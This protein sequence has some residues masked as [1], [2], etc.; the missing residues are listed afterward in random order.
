[1]KDYGKL[2]RPLTDLLK[3]NAFCWHE[4]ATKAFNQLKLAMS[5]PPVLVLPDFSRD[6]VVETDASNTRIGA[7]L[8]QQG[9]PIA[10]FSKSLAVQHQG[11]LVYGKEML[12]VVNAV[13]KWR[14]YLLGGHFIIKTDH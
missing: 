5:A 12:A 1:M 11:L 3:K 8:L 13:Q 14:P 7:V 6:F 9:R 4:G 2:A 10:F